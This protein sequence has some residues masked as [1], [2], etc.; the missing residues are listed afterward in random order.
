VGRT[1]C[2]LSASVDQRNEPFSADADTNDESLARQLERMQNRLDRLENEDRIAETIVHTYG[3]SVCLLHVVV[4]FRGKDSGLLIRIAP[5]ATGK[6]RVDDRVMVSLDTDGTGPPLQ[7]N[8]FGTVFLI[9]SDRRLLTNR[10]VAEPWAS[11]M[12]L[13]RILD[14]GATAFVVS[15][16]A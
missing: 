12:E 1:Q 3:P 15:Y 6:A 14:L 7:L 5:D 2:E 16:T 11:D 13:K 9:T 4:G 10:H 8:F